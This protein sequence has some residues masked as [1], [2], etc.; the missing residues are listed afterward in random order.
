MAEMNSIIDAWLGGE[1]LA[2]D[3]SDR[4]YRLRQQEIRNL[5]FTIGRFLVPKAGATEVTYNPVYVGERLHQA[6]G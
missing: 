1:S 3:L 5:F 2:G 4:P 6:A